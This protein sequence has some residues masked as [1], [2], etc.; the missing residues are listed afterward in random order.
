MT[1]LAISCQPTSGS[2]VLS[3][4]IR[5]ATCSGAALSNAPLEAGKPLSRRGGGPARLASCRACSGSAHEIRL[6]HALGQPGGCQAG[7]EWSRDDL[8]GPPALVRWRSPGG[9][10]FLGASGRTERI[11]SVPEPVRLHRLEDG[12]PVLICAAL[13][14]GHDHLAVG[15]TRFPAIG[16][17]HT[18][19]GA[20]QSCRLARAVAERADAGRSI[21]RV[22]AYAK[23]RVV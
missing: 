15:R 16:R 23:K 12:Q 13:R 9:L 21:A 18:E 17:W 7:R 14:R 10:R 4:R 19:R 8:C 2:L 1:I 6:R 11:A 22:R 20:G 3:G 5:A